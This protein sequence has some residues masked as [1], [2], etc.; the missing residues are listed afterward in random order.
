MN[1]IIIGEKVIDHD[2]VPFIIA[3]AGINHNGEIKKA[4]E[5]ITI[6]KNAGADAIKFQ[7]F[8]ASGIILDKSLTHTYVSQGKEIEESMYNMFERCE[9]SKKEWSKI[10]EKCVDKGILFLST[11][12]N[13]SDLELLLDLGIKAIKV[14]SD[15]FTN[16]P[17]LRDYAKTELPLIISC[18]MADLD[19]IKNTLSVLED[20]PII[21]MLTTSEYPTK[22]EN[23]NMLK[24][25]TLKN[26]FPNIILGYSDHTQGNLASVLAITFGARVFEKH[27]TLNNE[28]PGPDHWFSETPDTLKIWVESIRNAYDMLGSDEVKPTKNEEEIKLISRRSIV[29]LRDINKGEIFSRENIGA[30]RPGNG[31]PANMIEN[32]FG[33]KSTQNIKK[34]NF[35][36]KNNF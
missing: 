34:G 21:L 25:K 28:L 10:K 16:I 23:V 32:I 8:K 7:T 1:E 22:A 27:F 13:Q 5:M 15:D 29:A 2:S 17:L 31:L 11:P 4:I 14:G 30:R 20:Y 33:K 6:A 12:E 18:G 24:L 35:L 3:E 26:N 9:F 36:R 19:E